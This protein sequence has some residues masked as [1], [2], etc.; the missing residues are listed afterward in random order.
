[1]KVHSRKSWRWLRPAVQ[2]AFVTVAA[3]L[4]F[5]RF[6]GV[7]CP[8]DATCPFGGVATMWQWIANGVFLR[9]TG[10]TNLIL[11]G[12]LLAISLVVGRAFCGWACPLGTVQEWIAWLGTRINGGRP[13]G[14]R[15]L[16]P[17]LDR[18]LRLGKYVVLGLIVWASIRAVVPPLIP[19][20]PYRTL[21][22]LN[23]GALLGWGVLAAFATL[24]LAVERFWCR[25]LCPLGAVLVLTNRVSLWRV[26][27]DETTCISC[28]RCDRAC[29]VDLDVAN[30]VERGAE[31]IRC[32]SCVRACPKENA[33]ESHW[34]PTRKSR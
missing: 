23:V 12:T 19:F 18:P 2:V 14:R 6:W 8:F 32:L 9:E 22:T 25:Y 5:R 4:G 30:E 26:R 7:T 27:I 29:P 3:V 34:L 31:C 1:M 17:W 21:F 10:P 28:G 15:N 13:L 24:S 16:P 20:C 33:L 11:L